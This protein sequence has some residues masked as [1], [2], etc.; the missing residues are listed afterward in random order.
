MERL[1]CLFRV[2]FALITILFGVL[3]INSLAFDVADPC[4][5]LAESLDGC[6]VEG[7]AKKKGGEDQVTSQTGDEHKENELRQR[8]YEHQRP[9]KKKY[10]GQIRVGV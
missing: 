4:Y 10:C 9:N 5:I 3:F 8:D 6:I 2:L 7:Q 1:S